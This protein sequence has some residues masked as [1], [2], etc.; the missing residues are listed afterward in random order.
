[1]TL[2]SEGKDFRSC[3][4]AFRIKDYSLSLKTKTDIRAPNAMWD[5]HHMPYIPLCSGK[6]DTP[7]GIN[8]PVKLV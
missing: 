6:L 2:V 4:P 5:V 7:L 3:T 1:M 8:V